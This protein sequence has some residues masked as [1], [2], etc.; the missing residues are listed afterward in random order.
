MKK[1]AEK[2]YKSKAW[3]NC[4]DAY[5]KSVGQLCED[6]LEKGIYRSGEIVHHKVELSP[7]NIDD[8]NITLNWGNLR[9]LCRDCH[10]EKHKK[11]MRRYKVD[12]CGR[13]QIKG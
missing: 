8:P 7:E 13:I 2:F 5:S 1:F 3:K 6:C 9:L 11:S 4:R 10:A 12:E